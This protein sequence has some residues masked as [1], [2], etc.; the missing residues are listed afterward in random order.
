MLL[1]LANLLLPRDEQQ[2]QKYRP[3]SVRGKR[4]VLRRTWTLNTPNVF[5][6]FVKKKYPQASVATL[7]MSFWCVF[8]FFPLTTVGWQQTLQIKTRF[9]K[10][11]ECW[12]VNLVLNDHGRRQ[13]SLE[14]T[15]A[16]SHLTEIFIVCHWSTQL[17]LL[18]DVLFWLAIAWTQPIRTALSDQVQPHDFIHLFSTWVKVLEILSISYNYKVCQTHLVHSCIQS[19]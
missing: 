15:S 2:R 16:V 18:Y 8:S 14:V 10:R 9:K 17:C 19:D 12:V 3:H 7:T 6:I 5:S 13:T 4:S 11:Q 1:P